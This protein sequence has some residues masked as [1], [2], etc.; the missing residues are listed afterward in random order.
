MTR[1]DKP[2]SSPFPGPAEPHVSRRLFLKGSGATIAATGVAVP[3]AAQQ[4]TPDATPAI[5]AQAE[6]AIAIEFFNPQESAMV[7][8]LTARLLPGTPDD[9]GARE[10]GVVYY[11]DRS[12]AGTNE[13]YSKK[14]Y[15]QGPFLNVT[16]DQADVEATSRTDIYQ[17]VPAREADVS[18]YGYQ[19]VL[20]PQELYRRALESLGVYAEAEYGAPFVELSEAQQDEIVTA[21]EADEVPNFEAPSGGAFFTML[22]NGTIEGVF[23]DPL[24][25]GNRDMVG[26]K[27]IGFP[28]A[29]GFYT[30]EEMHDPGFS[31]EPVSLA[32]ATGH[33]H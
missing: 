16:E 22:R 13:G 28:G 19:S 20:T 1:S 6:P 27:L 24:Y 33:S 10:A 30:A 26:W 21:L 8:A 14:T 5:T 29:R 23:S 4:A 3:V 25:G 12:L 15:T 11:I 31:A 17:V 9:P 7:E 32:D 2:G 18:R